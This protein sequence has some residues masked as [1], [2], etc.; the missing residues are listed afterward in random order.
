MTVYVQQVTYKKLPTGKKEY[1]KTVTAA[2][3]NA[4]KVLIQNEIGSEIAIVKC[5]TTVPST[6]TGASNPAS[7]G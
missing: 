2:T 3:P 6:A 1:T 4:A 7:A 5:L